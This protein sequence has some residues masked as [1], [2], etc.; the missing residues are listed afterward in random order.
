MTGG[1][2]AGLSVEGSSYLIPLKSGNGRKSIHK[3]KQPQSQSGG[4]RRRKRSATTA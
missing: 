1:G 3:R 2:S 4:G